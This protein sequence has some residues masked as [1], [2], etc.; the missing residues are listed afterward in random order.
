MPL[1]AGQPAYSKSDTV[2][3]AIATGHGAPDFQANDFMTTTCAITRIAGDGIGPEVCQ[4][5]VAVRREAGGR[6]MTEG[7]YRALISHVGG[8]WAPGGQMATRFRQVSRA[9]FV[10]SSDLAQ[11]TRPLR[12]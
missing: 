11:Q 8:K 6:T 10:Q 3:D 9:R 4:S 1:P 7:I 2:M 12:K 5:A